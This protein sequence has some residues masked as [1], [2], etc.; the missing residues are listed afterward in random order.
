M[1]KY[2]IPDNQIKPVR[3]LSTPEQVRF[4]ED[5]RVSG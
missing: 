3:V 4:F 2:G 5:Q 1:E